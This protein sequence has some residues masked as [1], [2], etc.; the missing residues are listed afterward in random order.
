MSKPKK[1]TELKPQK[2]IV[3]RTP[4]RS[5]GFHIQVSTPDQLAGFVVV[6]ALI[7]FEAS[8]DRSKSPASGCDVFSLNVGMSVTFTIAGEI[9][10]RG[11]WKGVP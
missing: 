4:A 10:Y 5:G 6:P 1:A 3:T 11:D 2:W 9:E 8:I 7:P